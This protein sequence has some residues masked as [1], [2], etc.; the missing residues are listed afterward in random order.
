MKLSYCLE[1]VMA[2]AKF[3]YENNHIYED[4][5]DAYE[6]IIELIHEYAT[7]DYTSA[8]G[9]GGFYVV[10]RED[11]ED[12]IFAD[13]LVSPDLGSDHMTSIYHEEEL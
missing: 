1:N 6:S 10:F 5:Q 2:A 3:I 12:V 13:V 9:M 7:N 8:V 4:P 11:M